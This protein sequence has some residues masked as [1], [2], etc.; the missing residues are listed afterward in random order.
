MVT[1]NS[2]VT[3]TR[4]LHWYA[5]RISHSATV[6]VFDADLPPYAHL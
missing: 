3:A 2:R 1:L 5:C 6:L 4:I